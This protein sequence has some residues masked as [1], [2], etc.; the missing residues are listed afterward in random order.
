MRR[1][2]VLQVV[3]FVQHEAAVGRQHRGLEPVIRRHT[4]R[5]IG[6]EQMVV[7]HHH[8]GLGGPAPRLE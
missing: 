6:R 2:D 3:R 4:H 1:G 5:E 7:H 8:V